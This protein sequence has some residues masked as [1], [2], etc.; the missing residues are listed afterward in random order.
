MPR[1]RRSKTVI[2]QSAI[3]R[4]VRNGTNQAV[5]AVKERYT[6]KAAGAN[7]A[8]DIKTIMSLM[9][10]E[11]KQVYT[12]ATAQSVGSGAALV[13]GI[14]TVAQGTASNQRT[15]DSI[16]INRIDLNLKFIYSSGTQATS[17][18]ATQVFNW[19]LIRYLKTPATSGTTAFAIS[20]FL[21]TDGD[22][23]YTPLSFPNPDTNQN[24]QLMSSGSVELNLNLVPATSDAVSKV[25]SVSH[26]CSFHQDY[27][28]AASTTITENMTFLVFTALNAA[29]AGGV[30]QV[31]VNAAMWYI[32][33]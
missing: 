5:A 23:L 7:I 10:T 25:V 33:N 11:N 18:Q 17:N 19:Y 31:V 21:N 20:E 30:S 22:G 32:D 26:P 9:N 3:S 24:F 8:K 27:S 16:K 2:G 13:Y 28:G 1:S 14:G 29:N 6:G 15:G 12:L 4:F